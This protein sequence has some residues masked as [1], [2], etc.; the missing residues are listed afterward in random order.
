MRSQSST[1]TRLKFAA[2]V[3]V[4]CLFALPSTAQQPAGNP[5]DGQWS[6]TLDQSTGPGGATLAV[7]GATISPYH[8]TYHAEKRQFQ[9]Q[10]DG[11][12]DW[13]ENEAGTS[14]H[15]GQSEHFSFSGDRQL[16]L[17]A[18]GKVQAPQTAGATEK[19]RRL[20][21]KLSVIGGNGRSTGTS[22]S[23]TQTGIGIVSAD[24]SQLTNYPGGTTV[25]NPAWVIEWSELKPSSVQDEELGPETIRRTTTYAVTRE[26]RIPREING[27]FT[28][29]MTE[30]LEIKH[31]R[32]LDL[33]PRG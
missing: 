27:L 22:L 5:F 2:L 32:Y 6:L 31:V 10:A 17:R 21:L 20:T 12:I 3:G 18:S 28:P 26:T 19:D 7:S 13:T 4:V 8:C 15:D 16:M 11:T 23:G 30:R 14:S 1:Q 29:L 24:G 9:V 25:P 33:V